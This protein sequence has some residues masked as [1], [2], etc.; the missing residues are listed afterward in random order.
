MTQAF[1]Q[2]RSGQ[3]VV[4]IVVVKWNEVARTFAVVE[5]VWEMTS[6]KSCKYGEYRSFE[7]FLYLFS[8]ILSL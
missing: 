8:S 4:V 7:H 3:F 5:Y 2:G 6:K 1:T